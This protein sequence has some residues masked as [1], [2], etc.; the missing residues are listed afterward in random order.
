MNTFLAAV[1]E[2][3]GLIATAACALCVCLLIWAIVLT[4]RLRIVTPHMR[5][6]VRDMRGMNAADMLKAHLANVE[7]AIRRAAEATALGEEVS[8]RQCTCLRRVALVKYN[9]DEELG[10]EMSFSAALL[11]ERDTG[12]ILTSIYRLEECRIYAKRVE[13]GLPQQRLSQEEQQALDEALAVER[14]E[15]GT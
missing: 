4:R 13:G 12:F 1:Q 9:A 14:A 2:H 8:R 15:E 10:G 11:D 5:H 6:L 3:A 7:L